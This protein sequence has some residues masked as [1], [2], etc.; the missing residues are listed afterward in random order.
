MKVILDLT[1][2]SVVLKVNY[3]HWEDQAKQTFQNGVRDWE[4]IFGDFAESFP[5]TKN[6]EQEVLQE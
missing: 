1:V 2:L 4:N 5:V 3:S 6:Q